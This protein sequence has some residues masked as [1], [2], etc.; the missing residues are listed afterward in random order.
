LGT[1]Q[2]ILLQTLLTPW[3]TITDL[4]QMLPTLL[5]MV[6]VVSALKNQVSNE[7]CIS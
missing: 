3:R 5:S 4:R 6:Y 7:R 1:R 2:L